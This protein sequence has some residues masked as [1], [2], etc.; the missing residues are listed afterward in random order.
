MA[1]TPYG[2]GSATTVTTPQTDRAPQ[3]TLGG[4]AKRPAAGPR[5]G[6]RQWMVGD[7]MY[8]WVLVIIEVALMGAL[9]RRFRRHH[10]G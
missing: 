3:G 5:P 6:R 2:V 1:R 9:R 10:G 7:E 4:P 8:L